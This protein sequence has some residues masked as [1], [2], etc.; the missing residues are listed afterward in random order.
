MNIAV[1]V[2]YGNAPVTIL[3]PEG[4]LD[5]GNYRELIAKAAE[6]YQLGARNLLLDL[7][8]VSF[9]SSAGVVALH[10][11]ALLMEGLPLAHIEDG[12]HSIKRANMAQ[13]AGVHKHLK[14]LNLQPEVQSV[15]EML[16][17][18][19]HLDIYEDKDIALR[20]F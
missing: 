11:I 1:S 9:I 8:D 5:G 7:A 18:T 16:G 12:W 19:A 14:L 2:E 6:V 15:L 3:R 10:T 4:R 13:P 17:F 20:A